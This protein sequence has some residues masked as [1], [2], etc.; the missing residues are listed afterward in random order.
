MKGSSKKTEID[1]ENL[2]AEIENQQRNVSFDTKEYTIELLGRCSSITIYRIFN[3][4]S[5]YSLYIFS[6]NNIWAI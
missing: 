6:R 3:D 2:E 5:S 1:I 4:W